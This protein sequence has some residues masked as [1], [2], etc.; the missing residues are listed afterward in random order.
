MISVVWTSSDK[1]GSRLIRWAT[2]AAASHVA[3]VLDSRLVMHSTFSKGVHLQWLQNFL[4]GRDIIYRIDFIS[5]PLKL[6]EAVYLELISTESR[7]YDFGA[8]IYLSYRYVLHKWFKRPLPKTN[9]MASSNADIC[10]ELLSAL[11]AAGIELPRLDTSHPEDIY[12][13][14]KEHY[15]GNIPYT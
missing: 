7:N 11:N 6:E 14:L 3:F 15:D 2:G 10:L 1:V 12:W 4:K 5:M 9:N 8:F 13:Y